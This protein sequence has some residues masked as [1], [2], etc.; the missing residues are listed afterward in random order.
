MATM[1]KKQMTELIASK[2]HVDR[3]IVKKILHAFLEESLSTLVQGDRIEFRDFGV[4][5]IVI[6]KE[7]VGRNPKDPEHTIMI[8]ERRVVKF[9]PGKKMK[10]L[11]EEGS[12]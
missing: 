3:D 8:P 6:R 9:V 4:F 10:K 7:K 2:Y 12:N 11:V 1:T 5:E